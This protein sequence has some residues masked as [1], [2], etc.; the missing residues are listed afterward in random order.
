MNKSIIFNLRNYKRASAVPYNEKLFLIPEE[1]LKLL[2]Q[3]IAELTI[4]LEK[5]SHKE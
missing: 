5:L 1:D 4:E 2:Y 3:E